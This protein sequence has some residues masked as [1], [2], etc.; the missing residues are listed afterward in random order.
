[1]PLV[2]R[3]LRVEVLE[4]VNARGEVI[5]PLNV[6]QARVVARDLRAVGVEAVTVC[7]LHAYVN[8]THELQMARILQEEY[9]AALVS[10]SNQISR[11]W[12]EYERTSTTVINAYIQPIVERYL[13]TFDRH[14]LEQG[15]RGTLLIMQ[16]NGGLMPVDRTLQRPVCTI[17]SGPAAGAIATGVVGNLLGL[18]QLISFDMGGTTAKTCLVQHGA[19]RVSAEYRVNGHVLRVPVIDIIEVS[20]GGG[21]IAWVDEGGSLHVGP[22][23]AGADPGPV[24]YQRGGTAPTLTDA[25]LLL[26]RINPDNFLG[27]EMH[28]DRSAA[29]LAV[30]SHIAQPLGLNLITA[31]AGIIR[32]ADVKM[33]HAI[34]A[35]TIEQGLDPRDFTLVAYG[36][37]GP[38]HAAALAREL[39]IPRVLI[40][41]HPAYFSAWGML[42]ADLRHDF[43]QTAPGRLEQIDLAAVNAIF[44]GMMQ[45][46]REL[47]TREGMPPERMNLM[48][49]IDLR[50]VGQEH[51]VALPV[52]VEPLAKD[53]ASTLRHRFDELH[54]LTYGYDATDVEVE[55]VNLRLTALGR[56]QPP[57]FEHFAAG[58]SRSLAEAA[59]G[60]R[61]VYFAE[62]QEFSE[63]PVYRRDALP[64][65][66]VIIGPALVEE[67][68]TVT[69]VYP[70]D[71]L[72]V[73]PYGLLEIQISN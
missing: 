42:F 15:F 2:P 60:T 51:T 55:I 8:P 22:Q 16:S 1:E 52:E 65:G 29:E 18:D 61:Q 28:L 27:G 64:A 58:P 69:V 21:S 26:G 53:D 24:C 32:L 20:A 56:I 13:R 45:E 35:I 10:L 46:G 23:S 36:G 59:R 34:R 9:P 73:T 68:A 63:C 4:R 44:A 31:S 38:L 72:V 33:A 14:L 49:S 39:S 70:G 17:E 7:F 5:T 41:L 12:R 37:A 54:K 30:H 25:N 11:E 43:V 48:R 19:P 67:P 66:T 6:E 3:R 62:Q 50:Y 47:L 57:R 71:R 40:P